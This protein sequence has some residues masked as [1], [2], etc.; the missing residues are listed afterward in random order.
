MEP[1]AKR[2]IIIGHM[3]NIIKGHFL[4]DELARR[5]GINSNYLIISGDEMIGLAFLGKLKDLISVEEGQYISLYMTYV[6]RNEGQS[7]PLYIFST[8]FFK[9][10]ENQKMWLGFF[11]RLRK[12]VTRQ[13]HIVTRQKKNVIVG[14]LQFILTTYNLF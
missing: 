6:G 5:L 3:K 9:S 7:F 10:R 1:E 8:D 13:A 4:I 14:H 11:Q 12:L 2:S